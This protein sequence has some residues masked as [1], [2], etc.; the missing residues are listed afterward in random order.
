MIFED[1]YIKFWQGIGES[2]KMVLS[3]SLDDIVTSRTMSI[4]ILNE[5]FYFQTDRTFR[6]YGQLMGNPNVALCADNIQIEGYCS[7]L[8]IPSEN[9]EFSNAYKKYFPNS[10]NRYSS[11]ENERLFAVTPTFIERWLYI[12]NHPYMETFDIINQKYDLVQ[13]LGT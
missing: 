12:D 7:E 11:L 3:T 13:Y 6:K 8:G 5:K 2:K 4:V 10:Y 1:A 9:A